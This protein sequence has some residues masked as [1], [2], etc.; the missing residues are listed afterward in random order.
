[1]PRRRLTN[2]PG[3]QTVAVPFGLDARSAAASLD[4]RSIRGLKSGLRRLRQPSS[5]VPNQHP[6]L[7]KESLL[8]LRTDPL[9]NPA[10]VR[11]QQFSAVGR[12]LEA[13][14]E[15]IERPGVQIRVLVMQKDALVGGVIGGRLNLTADRHARG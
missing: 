12:R 1:M 3:P 9:E 5:E 7:F 4:R 10:A 13:E 15:D 2:L 11:H 14:E 8:D 6:S